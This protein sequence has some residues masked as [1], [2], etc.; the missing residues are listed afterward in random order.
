[1]KGRAEGGVKEGWRIAKEGD[2]VKITGNAGK[3]ITRN[4]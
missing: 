2:H 1:M 4:G 3:E